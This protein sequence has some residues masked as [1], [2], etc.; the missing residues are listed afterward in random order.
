MKR[1]VAAVMVLLTTLLPAVGQ[2]KQAQPQSQGQSDGQSNLSQTPGPV[3]GT[4]IFRSETR[5]VLITA[6]VWKRTADKKPDESLVPA[7][8][9][10]NTPSMFLIWHLRYAKKLDLHVIQ[11]DFHLFDNGIEQHISYFKKTVSPLKD[12]TN[13][14]ETSWMFYPKIRGTWGYTP[15]YFH[16]FTVTMVGAPPGVT[17]E[18]VGLPTKRSVFSMPNITYVIGYVPP[19]VDPGKCHDVRV[20][21][22]NHDVGLDRNQYCDAASSSNIDDATVEGTEIGAKMREF[23]DSSATGSIG[24]SARAFTFWS[25]R[26]W[27]FATQNTAA[28]STSSPSSDL[29]FAVEGRGSDAPARIHVAVEFAPAS[30]RWVLNCGPK[31]EALHV[32]GIAYKENH[33][34]AGQFGDTFTCPNSELLKK[35]LAIQEDRSPDKEHDLGAPNRLD[36]QMDL[37]PGDYDLRVV[38]SR[39]DKEF[40]R[41]QL[42][43]HVENFDGQHVALSDLALSSFPRDASKVI[44][45]AGFVSPAQLA[46]A[47]LIGKNAQFLPDTE[48]RIPRH[49]RLPAYF[50]IYEPLL[51]QQMTDVYMHLRVTNLKTGLVAMDSGRV[52]AANWVLTGN[53]VI[54]VGFSLGTENLDKGNYLLEVQ[55]SDPTGRESAWRRANFTITGD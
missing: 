21:V 20:E 6:G 44:D 47:P 23:A 53:P 28:G 34:I 11:S 1:T 36:A 35:E 38:V 40:G 41:S 13:E 22:E 3:N 48:T 12:V 30:K 15:G 2:T 31:A 7:D 33:Q 26:S 9:V 24:V 14:Y 42:P 55:A 5:L 52:S 39:G 51:K 18:E 46:P 10:K 27:Y 37:A 19:A 32:L 54:P 49:M 45:D 4:P 43:L 50:E 16:P 8:V 17:P 29:N 25:S